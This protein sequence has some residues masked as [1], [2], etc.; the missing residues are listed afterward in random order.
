MRRLQG[1]AVYEEPIATVDVV[2]HV[3]EV[4]P[5]PLVV[6]T[7]SQLALLAI[8]IR[9]KRAGYHRARCACWPSSLY[10]GTSYR[11]G[12]S[13]YFALP[14]LLLRGTDWPVWRAIPNLEVPV[15]ASPRVTRALTP[16]AGCSAVEDGQAKPRPEGYLHR[17]VPSAMEPRRSPASFQRAA[18]RYVPHWT[19][20]DSQSRNL[21][22]QASALVLSGGHSR[23]C[24]ACGR[25]RAGAISIFLSVPAWML[26]TYRTGAWL[27]IS[28]F[29]SAPSPP[30][31][32]VSERV[33]A[34]T[35]IN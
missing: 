1:Q 21:L 19:A 26:T 2:G 3:A 12:N 4:V 28:R 23:D 27:R 7:G 22:L 30:Y 5:G 13:Y 10:P 15:D 18:R 25:S 8:P 33:S 34:N 11:A 29:F 14:R 6:P 16:P 24:R 35:P 17:P 32:D 9:E 20:A 31:W